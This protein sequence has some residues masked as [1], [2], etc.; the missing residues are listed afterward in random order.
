MP[1]VLVSVAPRSIV[2]FV[3]LTTDELAEAR[4][5]ETRPALLPVASVRMLSFT[6]VSLL[7]VSAAPEA[8]VPA[9]SVAPERT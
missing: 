3:L 8:F 4:L 2:V 7:T 5:T 9:S 1:N 6:P